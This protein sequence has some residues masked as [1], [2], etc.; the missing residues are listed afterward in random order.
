MAIVL[1]PKKARFLTRYP[2][3]PDPL[4][5]LTRQASAGQ[6]ELPLTGAQ[7]QEGAV[8]NDPLRPGKPRKINVLYVAG[9]KESQKTLTEL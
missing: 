9:I 5:A 3:F 2:G 6:G 1:A 7:W 8:Q 4:W